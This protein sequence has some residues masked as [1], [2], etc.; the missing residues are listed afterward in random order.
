[1]SKFDIIDMF[2]RYINLWIFQATFFRW[3]FQDNIIFL[4]S[5]IILCYTLLLSAVSLRKI[6]LDPLAPNFCNGI[7]YLA[8][9][10]TCL[11]N[12]ATTIF[13]LPNTRQNIYENFIQ[14]NVTAFYNVKQA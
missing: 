14:N 6:D 9:P 2:F 8:N 3:N 1:M 4:L 5:E 13:S 12:V 11:C 7:R 10:F